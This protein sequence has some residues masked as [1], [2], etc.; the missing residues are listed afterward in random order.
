MSSLS[1][2]LLLSIRQVFF[3]A[4][5]PRL[6]RQSF[7]KNLSFRS[8]CWQLQQSSTLLAFG[9]LEVC[10]CSLRSLGSLVL[11]EVDD[12]LFFCFSFNQRGFFGEVFEL[13]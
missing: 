11:G 4:L 3:G 8:D 10:C 1:G 2:W 13:V 5:F 7:V 9:R 12:L 6:F